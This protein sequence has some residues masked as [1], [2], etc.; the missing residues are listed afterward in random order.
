MPV[1]R[2]FEFHA[3]AGQS[4]LFARVAVSPDN[5]Q[6]GAANMS[7]TEFE[8]AGD[9]QPLTLVQEFLLFIRQNK[10]WWLIPILLVLAC[11]G[12]LAALAPTGAAP[13]IYSL[14]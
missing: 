6:R 12:V 8:Q 4:G 14:F 10:K 2:N 9:D 7:R 13:F 3:A 11:V 5:I 1:G